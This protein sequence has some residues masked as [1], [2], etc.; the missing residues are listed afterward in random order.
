MNDKDCPYG[1][2]DCP[3]TENIDLQTKMISKKLDALIVI[4]LILH[5]AEIG[6][7]LL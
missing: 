4:F 3:K 1:A 5:G 7:L 2:Q 6:A